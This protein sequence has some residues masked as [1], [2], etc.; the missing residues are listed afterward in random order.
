[1]GK[2]ERTKVE[3]PQPSQGGALSVDKQAWPKYPI[4]PPE[5]GNS[6]AGLRWKVAWIHRDHYEWTFYV[7]QARST[8]TLS[9]EDGKMALL[10]T[11]K[12]LIRKGPDQI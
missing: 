10:K 4:W 11:Y 8:L 1:M 2:N 12:N 6:F 3:S 7:F 9:P 5:G